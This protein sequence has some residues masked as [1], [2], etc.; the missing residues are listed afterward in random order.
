MSNKE[1][2]IK[3]WEWL[4]DNAEKYPGAG[5]YR[6]KQS[7]FNALGY[8]MV[9]MGCYACHEVIKKGMKSCTACP[10]Y[11]KWRTHDGKLADK[12]ESR[13]THYNNWQHAPTVER[14]AYYAGMMVEN[15]REEWPD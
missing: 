6:R 13:G 14:R 11:K 15:I 7:A 4:R 12:C 10:M 1:R 8:R 9:S 5:A 2:C 3:V